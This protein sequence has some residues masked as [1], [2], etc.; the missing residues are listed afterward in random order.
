LKLPAKETIID[1]YP[2][3]DDDLENII[4]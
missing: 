2:I 1:V 3:D 4:S